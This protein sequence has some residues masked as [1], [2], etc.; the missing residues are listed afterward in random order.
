MATEQKTMRV[1]LTVPRLPEL[2]LPEQRRAIRDNLQRTGDFYGRR[3]SV[4]S[5]PTGLTAAVDFL[6][7]WAESESSADPEK[8]KAAA[9]L[10][11]AALG[12]P[13]TRKGQQ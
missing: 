3:I 1:L 6:C 7:W 8:L 5:M 13:G 9:K 2:T 12:V 10:V 4:R 11:R